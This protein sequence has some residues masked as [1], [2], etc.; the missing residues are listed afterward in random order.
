MKFWIINHKHWDNKV[1][2]STIDIF[3]S[4]DDARKYVKPK[5]SLHFSSSPALTLP[6]SIQEIE[7]DSDVILL[8]LLVSYSLQDLRG[9]VIRMV[10][11]QHPAVKFGPII[12]I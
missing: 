1:G 4:E 8:E 5:M 6:D 12:E 7:I 2:P 10:W 11:D 3:K 9:A